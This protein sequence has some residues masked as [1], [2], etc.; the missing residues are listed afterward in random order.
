MPSHEIQV[1]ALPDAEVL[2]FRSKHLN[3]SVFR[4]IQEELRKKGREPL[5]IGL[6]D[7]ATLES[8]DREVMRQA[9]WIRVEDCP[10]A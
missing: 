5:I 1:D 4:A 7:T 2:V 10:D 8:A 3:S 6:E 9:G